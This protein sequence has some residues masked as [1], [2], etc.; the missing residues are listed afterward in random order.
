MKDNL[1]H[2]SDIQSG[3]NARLKKI[4]GGQEIRQRLTAMGFLPEQII[5]VVKNGHP[6]PLVVKVK[7][8][9]IV[10]GRGMSQKIKVEKI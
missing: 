5:L 7:E 1:L 8:S 6:G 9:K 4:I 2:L 10:L 3:Q